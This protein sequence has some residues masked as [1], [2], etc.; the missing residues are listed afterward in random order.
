MVMNSVDHR[1]NFTPYMARRTTFLFSMVIGS[2]IAFAQTTGQVRIISQPEQGVR[3]VLDGKYEMND[4]EITLSEGDH[5]F[6]FWAPEHQ[7]L[8]TTIFVMGNYTYQLNVQL[9]RPAE[10]VAYRSALEK[11]THKQRLMRTVPP[12][13][14]GGLGIWTA[15]SWINLGKAHSELQEFGDLYM[16][17]SNPGEIQRLKET[18][19]PEAKDR[20]RSAR[21]QAYVSTGLFVA[22]IGAVAYIRS[23]LRKEQPPAYEDKERVRFEGLVWIP[24]GNNGTWATSISIP[25]R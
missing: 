3:Y 24:G 1:W 11:H 16:T 15:I 22:S 12:I 9:Q 25:L 19:I 14:A 10:Y 7:M 21:T 2:G 6:V 20:F 23:Q 13:V 8:D 17:S 18:D 4:R 5:R